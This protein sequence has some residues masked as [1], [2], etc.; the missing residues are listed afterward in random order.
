MKTIAPKDFEAN[1]IDLFLAGGISN[2]P[3]WQ[4]DALTMLQDTHLVVANPRRSEGLENT[5][6]E[7]AIQIAWEQQA[8]IKA[9]KILFWF[10]EETLC[11]ITLLE[12]GVQIGKLDK[13]I[14]VGTHPNYARRFDIIE[15]LGLVDHPNL[16]KTVHNNLEDLI[17]E[18]KTFDK[19]I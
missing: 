13:P 6:T 4:A 16:P 7:A 3:D 12:L 5:G 9:D 19:A 2:C 8:L 1:H 18:V 15:Q 14:F 10:P 11:P 17:A